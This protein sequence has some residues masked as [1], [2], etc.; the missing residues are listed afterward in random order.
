MDTSRL[1]LPTCTKEF[2]C[3]ALHFT[4]EVLRRSIDDHNILHCHMGR[5]HEGRWPRQLTSPTSDSEPAV[6]TQACCTRQL[7][8]LTIELSQTG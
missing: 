2:S 5:T 8:S 1:M 7:L 6:W 3:P 4:P